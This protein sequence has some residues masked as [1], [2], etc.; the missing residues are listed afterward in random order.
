MNPAFQS[1]AACTFDIK[2]PVLRGRALA[3]AVTAPILVLLSAGVVAAWLAFGLPAIE[4]AL[5]EGLGFVVGAI[6][7][8]RRE[9]THARRPLPPWL[10]RSTGLFN[11]AGLFAAA[12]EVLR[13]RD[14]AEP[15]T[16]IVLEFADLREAHDIYGSAIARKLVARI[17]RKLEGVAGSRG[18]VGRTDTAQF[19]IIL[20]G[21]REKKALRTLQRELGKPARIEFDAGDSEI[22]LVPDVLM[23]QA[24]VGE[25]SMH[26][27]FRGM[28]REM[29]R[30]QREEL[31][32]QAWLTRERERHSRPMSLPA[33]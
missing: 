3:V 1:T 31:R 5:V 17:V 4:A 9:D 24:E 22:V 19:T 15:T 28:C 10:D 23:D 13:S 30:R 20:P 2:Q 25:V 8:A 26:D 6:W 12:N 21:T 32:R 27:L 16:L 11:R 14:P 7:I 29:T 18:F 33:R